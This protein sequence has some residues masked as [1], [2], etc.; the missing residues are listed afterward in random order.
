[1]IYNKHPFYND[2]NR[3]NSCNSNS[4][5]NICNSFQESQ[6]KEKDNRLLQTVG[7]LF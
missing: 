4:C 3:C 5:D 7:Y 6:I 2:Y 1:M